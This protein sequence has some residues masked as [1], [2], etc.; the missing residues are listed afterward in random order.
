MAKKASGLPASF[1]IE[2][3]R[4]DIDDGPVTL[5]DY[6]DESLSPPKA[7]PKPIEASTESIEGEDGVPVHRLEVA[8]PSSSIAEAPQP[9]PAPASVPDEPAPPRQLFPQ[10]PP[11]VE[12][13]SRSL[14]ARAPRAS[15]VHRVQVNLSV[16]AK[17][18]HEAI[19]DYVCARS[20]QRDTSHTEVHQALL[21]ALEESLSNLDLKAVP[22]RGKWGSASARAFVTA[23]KTS[24][25]RAIATTYNDEHR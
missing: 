4:D 3:S 23:L 1:T 25:A 10:P 8:S 14:P 24:F 2:T 17:R 7:T 20:R 15:K 6:L 22:E 12:E 21:L 9:T 13:A 19:L 18:A 11:V 5:G 16:E